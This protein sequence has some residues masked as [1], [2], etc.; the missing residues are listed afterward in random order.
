MKTIEFVGTD[1][2]GKN[3]DFN[4]EEIGAIYPSDDTVYIHGSPVRISS[5]E[6]KTAKPQYNNRLN[7]G[8]FQKDLAAQRSF[9]ENL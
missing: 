5:V 1:F 2:L 8:E 4:F 3:V 7:V 6:V 9:S